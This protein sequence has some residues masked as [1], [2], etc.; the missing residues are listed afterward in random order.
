M[1]EPFTLEEA[2]SVLCYDKYDMSEFIAKES[3]LRSLLNYQNELANYLDF[4]MLFI[5]MTKIEFITNLQPSA[6]QSKDKEANF[7]F[8]SS[9]DI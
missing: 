3:E 1:V 9:P 5:K 2:K 4:A 6:D 7:A 8:K